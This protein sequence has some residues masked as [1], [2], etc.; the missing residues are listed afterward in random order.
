MELNESSF[1]V[2]TYLSFDQTLTK[3]GWS[4]VDCYGREVIACGMIKP[5]IRD[6]R[7]KGFELT[8]EKQRLLE[9][10]MLKVVAEQ[11][12]GTDEI[13]MEMP[14]VGGFRT[15]SSLL[16]ASTLLSVCRQLS[17]PVPRMVARRHAAS[18]TLGIPDAEKSES[19][20]FVDEVIVKKPEKSLW[21]HDIRDSVLL[22]LCEGLGND[23]IIFTNTR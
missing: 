19:S 4:K 21:N 23:S 15:E 1:R 12:E 7:L 17:L 6:H 20:A 9:V 22:A 11:A 10:G 14:S 8:F 3:T 2:V 16:A 13:L 18:V 5:D